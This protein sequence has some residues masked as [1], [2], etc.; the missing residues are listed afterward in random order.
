MRGYQYLEV[1]RAEAVVTVTLN[2]PDRLN[3]WHR[4]VIG[5]LRALAG[6]PNGLIAFCGGRAQE[7]VQHVG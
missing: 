5:E 6:P 2:R 4:E 3:A 1:D 7:A